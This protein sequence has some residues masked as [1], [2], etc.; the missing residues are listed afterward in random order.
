MLETTLEQKEKIRK[1]I[2]LNKTYQELAD[3]LNMN[4]RTVRKWGQ[5][6]KRGEPLNTKMGRPK[7][8]VLGSFKPKIK[9]LINEYRPQVDGWGAVTIKT[10]L[11][12]NQ[13]VM[14]EK[15]TI[16]KLDK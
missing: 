7:C 3:E 8:G 14:G 5:K 12:L 15:K 9:E 6:I 4:K 2:A 13:K 16:S 11:N 1:G 10:E